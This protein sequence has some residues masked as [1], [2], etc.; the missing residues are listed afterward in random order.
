M[1]SQ[2]FLGVDQRSGK[3]VMPD[4]AATEALNVDFYPVGSMRARNGSRVLA[5][6]NSPSTSPVLDVARLSHVDNGYFLYATTADG[7]YRTATD[8]PLSFTQRTALA[9]SATAA[10]LERARYV[11]DSNSATPDDRGQAIYLANGVDRPVVDTGGVGECI[12]IPGAE[13]GTGADDGVDGIPTSAT[14]SDEW[15]DWLTDPPAHFYLSGRAAGEQ[16]FAW[17]FAGDPERVDYSA[18]AKPWHWCRMNMDDPDAADQ[19]DVDGGYFYVGDGD[20]DPVVAVHRLLDRLI[21]LKRE[22]VYVYSGFQGTNL[23]LQAIHNVGCAS[24][25]SVV[26]AGNE[27]FWWSESGPVALSGVEQYGDL[28][29]SSVGQQ[30]WDLV[31]QVGTGPRY[32]L[33]SGFHDQANYRIVWFCPDTANPPDHRAAVMFY[34]QPVRWSTYNGSFCDQRAVTRVDGFFGSDRFLAANGSGG[35]EELF[36]GSQ[37]SA[38]LDGQDWVG[39][40]YVARWVSKWLDLG[41]GDMRARTLQFTAILG[42][43][44]GRDLVVYTSWDFADSSGDW[45]ASTGVARMRGNPGAY[46]G[47]ARW[48][49]AKWGETASGVRVYEA[50]GSG[51]HMKFMV[52]GGAPWSLDGWSLNASSKGRR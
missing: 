7:L 48:G 4:H 51:H 9:G 32:R 15:R 35:V 42:E 37:D 18:V 34:D 50:D 1:K 8:G 41:D 17:G 44:G 10:T 23:A 11:H 13:Y 21:V 52:E 45:R 39:S 36:F 49:Q 25:K 24:A 5:A 38:E 40:D 27:L 2:P 29:H 20:G 46:W 14:G 26:Q 43:E 28:A 30:V 33:I 16:M 47:F 12:D 6:V 3:I 22:R 31:R 19:P